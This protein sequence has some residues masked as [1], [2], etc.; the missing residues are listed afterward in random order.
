MPRYRLIIAYDGTDFHGWQRQPMGDDHAARHG[1]EPGGDMR[2]VQGVVE[3]AVRETLR[4][5]SIN[6]V[7]SSRTDAGVHALGQV[8]TFVTEPDP[9][10]GVGWPTERGCDTLAKALN[11]RLPRDILVREAH[12]VRD[13]FNPFT[14]AVSK[15]YTYTIATGRVR[16]LWQ[17]R[18]VFHTWYGLDPRLMRRGATDLVGEH[19]FVSFAQINHGR[20]TTVRTIHGCSV[21]VVTPG[22][23]ADTGLFV[24]EHPMVRVRVSGSGFLYNMVRIIAGT[25]MEIGRGSMPADAIPKIIASKDRREAGPT[26]PPQG[27]RLEW[28]EHRD[29]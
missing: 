11:S 28:I 4:E 10:R 9:T 14:D 1:F 3:D 16:A 5:P 7:G 20:T 24:D 25:L 19:D 8:A 13:D 18:Y 6:L 15:E 22:E 23:L 12:A 26:L 27:L 29:V 21:E 17:R 2:T